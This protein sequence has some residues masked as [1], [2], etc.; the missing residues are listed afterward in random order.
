M[1]NFF[2]NIILILIK[3]YNGEWGL[4]IGDWGVG[5]W[6]WGPNPK[7]PTPTPH[8]PTPTKQKKQM[9]NIYRIIR[10]CNELF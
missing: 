5:G 2:Y 9:N 8:P 7:P 1:N 10:I 3:K 4:G 6:G